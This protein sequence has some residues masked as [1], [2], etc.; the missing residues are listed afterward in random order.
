MSNRNP[1]PDPKRPKR[2]SCPRALSNAEDSAGKAGSAHQPSADPSCSPP[3]PG[4]TSRTGQAPGHPFAQGETSEPTGQHPRGHWNRS[5]GRR[6]LSP[7]P[8]SAGPTASA[9]TADAAKPKRRRLP[10]LQTLLDAFDPIDELEPE[11]EP[12][13]FWIEPDAWNMD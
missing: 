12:G 9:K 7:R 6:D 5:A 8:S 1:Q 3:D 10:D 13:D 2:W 11:P 4:D